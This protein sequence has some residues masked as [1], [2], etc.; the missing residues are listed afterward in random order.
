MAKIHWQNLKNVF[1]KTTGPFST[2]LGTKNPWVKGFQVINIRGSAHSQR[3]DNYE[4]GKLNWQIWKIVFSKTTEPSST[5]IGTKHPWVKGI[6]VCSNE[7]LR[8]F[9]RGDNYEIAK[10]HWRIWKIFFSKTTEP[11]STKLGT[12]HHWVKEIQ[13]CSNEGLH[14]F[15]RAYNYEIVKIHWWILKIFSPE[16]IGQFLSCRL[17]SVV[18]SFRGG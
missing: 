6:Q 18:L 16:P 15:P 9:P 7:G 4:I 17:C 5:I 13:I 3:G 10:I 11:I 8:S 12:M 14:P 1:S 2:K